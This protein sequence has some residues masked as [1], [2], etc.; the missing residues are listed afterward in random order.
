MFAKCIALSE[1]HEQYKQN[2]KVSNINSKFYREGD[3]MDNINQDWIYKKS[4]VSPKF[5]PASF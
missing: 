3:Q 5:S 1:K 4:P 2:K